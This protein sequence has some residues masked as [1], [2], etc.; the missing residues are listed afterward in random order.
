MSGR[1][2]SMY[3]TYCERVSRLTKI[4][5]EADTEIE[6][7][8]LLRK[9]LVE[10]NLAGIYSDEIFKEQNTLIEDK[11]IKAH[12]KTILADLGET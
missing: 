3:K 9:V 6:N 2:K 1:C 4:K 10:K 8:K 12:L 11:M 5:S 7:L